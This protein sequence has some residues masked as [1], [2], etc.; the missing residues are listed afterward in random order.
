MAIHNG[1]F[2]V[3]DIM[4]QS[5]MCAMGCDKS[6]VVVVLTLILFVYLCVLY[7]TSSIVYM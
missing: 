7:N 6:I 3:T 1:S 4:L 5:Q 2:C